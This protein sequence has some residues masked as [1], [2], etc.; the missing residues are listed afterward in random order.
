MDLTNCCS[1]KPNI[2]KILVLLAFAF[3]LNAFPYK[4]IIDGIGNFLPQNG[5]AT[6]KICARAKKKKAYMRVEL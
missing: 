6:K 5:K 3:Q 1:C 4:F 2:S